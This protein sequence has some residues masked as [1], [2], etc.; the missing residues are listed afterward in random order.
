MVD[1]MVQRFG[2]GWWVLLIWGVLAVIFGILAV[3]SPL[4]TVVALA[5]VISIFV[6]AEGLVAVFTL[7]SS[8]PPMSRG[9]LLFYA[10][11]SIVFGVL[12][13]LYPMALAG[14][15]LL[16][17]AVWLLVA[18]ILRI[19]FA[20][21][22]RKEIKGEWI[23]ALSGAL[24]IIL[25]VLLLIAPLAGM[26]VMAIW[27]GAFAFVYGILQIVAAFRLRQLHRERGVQI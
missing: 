15:L 27:I 6:L 11:V 1:A 13:L 14:A 17:F 2:R 8:E 7:F 4:V 26:V 19:M 12:G 25:G 20:I 24:A 23:I 18:G 22:V 10:I 16:V 21:Q 3:I 9:W 5:V